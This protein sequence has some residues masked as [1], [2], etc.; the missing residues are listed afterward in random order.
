[1]TPEQFEAFMATLAAI[2]RRLA[3]MER[4][5]ADSAAAIEELA[6]NVDNIAESTARLQDL[7]VALDAKS[8]ETAAMVGN[9]V[10]ATRDLRNESRNLHTL[11]R[12]K[13]KAG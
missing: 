4:D 7:Y 13:L 1:M 5:S 8:D 9:Y 2:D 6:K 11:V 12:E 10:E 3:N